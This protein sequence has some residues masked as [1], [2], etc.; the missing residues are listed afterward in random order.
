M[1]KRT[2]KSILCIMLTTV[3]LLV[4]GGCS[5]NNETQYS[6]TTYT[7]ASKDETVSSETTSTRW[8]C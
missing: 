1:T 4:Y 3:I 6:N 7:M 5:L 8:D 2:L